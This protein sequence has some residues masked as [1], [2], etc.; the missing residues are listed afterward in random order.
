MPVPG[1]LAATQK[2]WQAAEEAFQKAVDINR[3]YRLPYYEARSLLELA[4][5]HLFRGESGDCEK[6]M[7]LLD[8]SLSIF[9]G[10]GA[11][12]MAERVLAQKEALSM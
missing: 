8:Q 11:A 10:M 5:M 12:K 9:Q 7:L 6:G 4:E 2:H 3:Q 1:T